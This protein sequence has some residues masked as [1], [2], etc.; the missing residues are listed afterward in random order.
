MYIIKNRSKY[1]L[2]FIINEYISFSTQ[3]NVDLLEMMKP[4]LLSYST[5]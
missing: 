4:C 5:V 3:Q 2:V 1:N